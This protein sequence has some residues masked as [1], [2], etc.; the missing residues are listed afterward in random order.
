MVVV[1]I[2]GILVALL[3]PAV[4]SARASARRMSCA[5]NLR[6][7]GLAFQMHH[8]AHGV[9]PTGGDDGPDDCCRATIPEYFCWTYHILPFI[10][11]RQVYELPE[12]ELKIT[13]V[14]TY[15]CPSRRTA[16]I[17]RGYAKADYA[18]NGGSDQLPGVVVPISR[19]PKVK[20]THITDG[21]SN[22]L[23]LSETRVHALLLDEAQAGYYSD[24][25]NCYTNGWADEVVRR[26][27]PTAGIYQGPKQDVYDSA[28]HGSEVHG[29]FGSSHIAGVNAV[30]CDGSARLI[31][32]DVDPT[33]FRWLCE[34]EDGQVLETNAL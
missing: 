23:M 33:L 11:Q 12:A 17:Y 22:T 32:Y 19:M 24:G 9:Y 18:A 13:P 5:N 21:L 28:I 14:E 4:Q 7:I 31:T 34:R 25:E 30:L 20:E 8:D 6:Q 2:I 26:S 15:H 27:L 29:Q 10:E 16:R 3:L 1:A